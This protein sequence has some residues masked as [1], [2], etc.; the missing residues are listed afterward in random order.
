MCHEE[1]TGKGTTAFRLEANN[2]NTAHLEKTHIR[3]V[4]EKNL[5]EMKN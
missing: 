1:D 2:E 5:T 4:K 3:N